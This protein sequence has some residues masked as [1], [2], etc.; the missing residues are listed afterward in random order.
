MTKLSD[1]VAIPTT[2]TIQFTDF[3]GKEVAIPAAL[4]FDSISAIENAYGKNYATFEKDLNVL[5]KRKQFKR[6]DK[7][8]KLI[9]SL[10]YGLFIGGGVDCTYNEMNQAIP[11]TELP[12]V[13]EQSLEII[14]TQGFQESDLKK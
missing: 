6:D 14:N 7:S 11:F 2:K 5:L 4:T 1:L 12:T 9:W 10:V 13:L 8:M 3:S